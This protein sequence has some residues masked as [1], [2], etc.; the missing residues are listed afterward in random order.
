MLNDG[1]SQGQEEE[2]GME[3]ITAKPHPT[4]LDINPLNHQI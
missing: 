3:L 2:A 4:M 1:Q